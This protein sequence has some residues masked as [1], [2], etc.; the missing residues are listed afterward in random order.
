MLLHFS[1]LLLLLGLTAVQVQPLSPLMVL[2]KRTVNSNSFAGIRLTKQFQTAATS[3]LRFDTPT[4][5]QGLAIP[6]IV[7]GKDVRIRSP[8]GSGKTAAYVLPLVQ[9]LAKSE[10]SARAARCLVLVPTRE[11]AVQVSD[12]FTLVSEAARCDLTVRCAYGG[13]SMSPQLRTLQYGVDVLVA[14]PGRLIDIMNNNGTDLGAVEH[15]VLDEADKLM[16][17]EFL[18]QVEKLLSA[19]GRGRQTIACSATYSKTVLERIS[20]LLRSNYVNV[21]DIIGHDGGKESDGGIDNAAAIEMHQPNITQRAIKVSPKKRNALLAKVA[22]EYKSTLVFVAKKAQTESVAE[23]LRSAGISATAVHG[24]LTQS[25]RQSRLDDFKNRHTRV[26]IAT[27]VA[28]RGID[29]AG[30]GLVVNYDLPRSPLEFRH[31]CGRTGRAGEKGTAI[32]FISA[33]TEAHFEL[34]EKKG[35]GGERVDKEVIE[36]FEID[37]VQWD[38]TRQEMKEKNK[39]ISTDHMMGGIKSTKKKSKK[40]KLREQGLL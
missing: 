26:C 6:P 1:F 3:K 22:G 21:G 8:T 11:L 7:D 25:V 29:V 12:V 33:E 31:R 28:A 34:I 10:P 13:V 40:D 9:H 18:E 19:L 24:D 20:K 17:G 32:S 2:I 36:G 39:E 16:S 23:S 30:L 35:L 4:P 27:D 37:R 38:R 5:V 14:T 15:L